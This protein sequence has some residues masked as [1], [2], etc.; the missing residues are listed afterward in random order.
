VWFSVEDESSPF[1]PLTQR[2]V[3]GLLEEN[4]ITPL[5][6]ASLMSEA[7]EVFQLLPSVMWPW[8]VLGTVFDRVVLCYIEA[9]RPMLNSAICFHS[10]SLADIV[11]DTV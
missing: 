8:D 11:L 7:G 6:D 9:R 1:G 10:W 2:L 5:D 3:Q 4:L